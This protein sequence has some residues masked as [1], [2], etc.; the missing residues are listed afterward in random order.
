MSKIKDIVIDV[1]NE[2]RIVKIK[3]QKL[4]DN[5]YEDFC[6]TDLDMENDDLI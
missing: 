3:E 2:I 4:N 5:D 6:L 1:Q